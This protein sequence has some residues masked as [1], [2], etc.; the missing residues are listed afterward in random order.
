MRLAH[1]RVPDDIGDHT[2]DDMA[3]A[4]A[5]PL[6]DLDNREMRADKRL[7]AGKVRHG[8]VGVAPGSIA[9]RGGIPP[10]YQPADRQHPRPRRDAARLRRNT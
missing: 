4:F 10:T 5:P 8:R 7:F 3:V 9:G 2:A 1:R 6:A